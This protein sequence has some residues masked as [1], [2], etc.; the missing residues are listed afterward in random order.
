MLPPAKPALMLVEDSPEDRE[1]TLRAFRKCCFE[2]PII[3]CSD[4][5]EAL[6]V[7]QRRGR[8]R[9]QPAPALVLLDLNM[10]GT[11][12]RTVLS[13]IKADPHLKNIPV[14]VLTTSTNRKDIA[15]SY[16]AGASSYVTK[17]MDMASFVST[18]ASLKSWWF[19]KVILPVHQ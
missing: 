8:Y 1:A 17:P 15:A 10:P 3:A 5:D 19:E 2:H 14:V 6:A 16:Q 4:G 7:L 13:R 12:G 11:D 18:I 9:D